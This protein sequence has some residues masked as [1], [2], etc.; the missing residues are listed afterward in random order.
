MRRH[1]SST[2][3]YLSVVP[4]FRFQ[5]HHYFKTHSAVG[6]PLNR[7]WVKRLGT[8]YSGER[9]SN[10]SSRAIR[11]KAVVFMHAHQGE[12]WLIMFLHHQISPSRFRSI[13][14]ALFSSVTRRMQWRSVSSSSALPT[15]HPTA[16]VASCSMHTFHQPTRT[17]RRLSTFRLRAGV[18]SGSI[19]SDNTHKC[20]VGWRRQC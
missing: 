12:L 11:S 16:T 2:L 20:H 14:A 19:R 13:P 1:S 10:R 17:L 5:S 8:E 15:R 7:A 4:W 18:Q 9:D 6:A 3:T